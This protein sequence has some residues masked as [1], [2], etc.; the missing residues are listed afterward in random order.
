MA[1]QNLLNKYISNG[2][3]EFKGLNITGSIPIKQEVIN[4]FITEILQNGIKLT[5]QS[6]ASSNSSPKPNINVDDLLKLIKRAEVKID[7][8]K[9]ILGFEIAI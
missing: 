6:Q 4:E 1:T 5:P 7:E 8:G 9:I 2:F 3:V